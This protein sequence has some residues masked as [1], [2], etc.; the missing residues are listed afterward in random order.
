MPKKSPGY[1]GYC[2]YKGHLVGRCTG[3]DSDTFTML[4][5]DCDNDAVKVLLQYTNFSEKLQAI[6]ERVAGIQAVESREPEVLK[7]RLYH[8]NYNRRGGDINDKG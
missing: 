2:Y 7:K 8:R 6:F 4:M 3:V 1:S 5:G